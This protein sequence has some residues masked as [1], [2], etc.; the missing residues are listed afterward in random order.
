MGRAR[1]TGRG[2]GMSRVACD[3]AKGNDSNALQQWIPSRGYQVIRLRSSI[4]ACSAIVLL[5]LSGHRA[6]SQV[7]Q[8]LPTI[9]SLI[10]HVGSTLHCR[11]GFGVGLGELL[12]II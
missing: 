4:I 8:H 12:K 7:T 6:W 2:G 5:A 9:V 3:P 10:L 1:A 11:S